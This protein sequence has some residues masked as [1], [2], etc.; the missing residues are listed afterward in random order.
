MNVR[1]GVGVV[2]GVGLA[3]VASG[4]PL[5][6]QERAPELFDLRQVRDFH[7]RFAD[8]DWLQRLERAGEGD[9]VRA[10]L[11]VDGVIYPG[12]GLRYKG[13]SSLRVTG[14]KKPFNLTIDAFAPGQRL[15]GVDSVNLNNSYADP[16]HLRE[17]LTNE[18]LRPLVPTPRRSTSTRRCGTWRR[19]TPS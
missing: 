9:N 19:R 7:V 4:G 5:R 10:D 3:L 6:A 14:P 11:T 13:L 16:S 18:L 8:A 17:V 15:Y 2:V 12:V 1:W